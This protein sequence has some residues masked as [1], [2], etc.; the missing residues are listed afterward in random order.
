MH[1]YGE[2]APWPLPNVWLG[3]SVEDQQRADERI[4]HLLKCPAAVRFLSCEPLLGAIDLTWVGGKATHYEYNRMDALTGEAFAGETRETVWDVT[5]PIGTGSIHWVIVGGESGPGARPM[6][7]EW[8]R[9]IVDQCAAAGVS[10]FCKQVGSVLA[11]E[12][13]S[14]ELK[15]GNPEFWPADIRVREMPVAYVKPEDRR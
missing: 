2:P 7:I 5:H 10:V 4:P 9:S 8:I 13:G 6:N 12:F 11:R 3:T 14:D 15:G 1:D